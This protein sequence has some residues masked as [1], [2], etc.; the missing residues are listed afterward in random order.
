MNLISAGFSGFALGGSLIVPIGAQNAFILRQGLI[1][2]HVF[3]LCLICAA[4]DAL[5]IA[6]GVGGLGTIVSQSPLLISVVTLG[7]A[8][9]LATYSAMAFRR[10]VKPG[11][12]VAGAP[13]SMALKAAVMTCL[14]FT[15]LNP[16]V[17]LDTVVLLGSLS[18]AYQGLERVA[19]GA[20]AVIAS[21]AWFFGLGYGARYLAPLFARPAAW[22][23]LDGLIGVVMG[24]LALGLLISFLRGA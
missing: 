23:V 9:F 5:L 24:L 7:G 19:Y 12:M 10:A 11:A 16:H 21:F 14:A 1:R 17:Y 20:G 6:A 15:F 18:A 2:S 13:E 3:V 8:L 22:R 4:S